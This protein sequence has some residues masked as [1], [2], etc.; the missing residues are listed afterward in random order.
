MKTQQR[1]RKFRRFIKGLCFL[2]SDKDGLPTASKA[3]QLIELR[4]VKEKEGEKSRLESAQSLS[5]MGRNA[6]STTEISDTRAPPAKVSSKF[7]PAAVP[8]PISHP[9]EEQLNTSDTGKTMHICDQFLKQAMPVGLPAQ[10][11]WNEATM[12]WDHKSI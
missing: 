7:D 1:R 5:A 6:L 4:T 10:G 2:S 12:T 3:V 11:L 8:V 9:P